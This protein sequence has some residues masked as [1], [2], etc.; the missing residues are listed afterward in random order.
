[1][2]GE[3]IVFHGNNKSYDELN[4]AYKNNVTIVLDNYHDIELLKEIVSEK[5]QVKLMLRMF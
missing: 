4:F 5:K 3:K 1:M 2:K